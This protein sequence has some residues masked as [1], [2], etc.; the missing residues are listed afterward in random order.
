[1]GEKGDTELNYVDISTSQTTGKCNAWGF[2]AANR[3]HDWGYMLKHK[4]KS[5]LTIVKKVGQ[6]HRVIRSLKNAEIGD[7]GLDALGIWAS[8]TNPF[9]VFKILITDT[10]PGSTYQFTLQHIPQTSQE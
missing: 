3:G 9:E 5:H 8:G 6:E 1:M 2:V 7:R 4:I 10:D